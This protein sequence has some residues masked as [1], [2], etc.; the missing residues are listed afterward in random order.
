MSAGFIGF[1]TFLVFC[2]IL[3]ALRRPV[4]GG[5]QALG[6]ID[7]DGVMEFATNQTS[8][9]AVARLWLKLRANRRL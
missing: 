6:V 8:H 4:G 9:E 1:Q 2:L 7:H 5:W 3:L